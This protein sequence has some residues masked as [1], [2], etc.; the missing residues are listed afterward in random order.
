MRRYRM[1]LLRRR[2]LRVAG[3]R[4]GGA[5]DDDGRGVAVVELMGRAGKRRR[6]S[7][8]HDEGK[9]LEGCLDGMRMKEIGNSGE[10]SRERRTSRQ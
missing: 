10:G 1:L 5:D 7:V 2:L 8:N 3:E 9:K 6:N 4:D